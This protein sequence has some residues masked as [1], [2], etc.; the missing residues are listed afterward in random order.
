MYESQELVYVQVVSVCET[1]VDKIPVIP[2]VITRKC[3][4]TSRVRVR[5]C[6]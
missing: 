6:S 1:L 5:Q 3:G 2:N 4:Q